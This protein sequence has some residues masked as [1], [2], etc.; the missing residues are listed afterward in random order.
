MGLK[1]ST[2]NTCVPVVWQQCDWHRSCCLLKIQNFSVQIFKCL[3]NLI[4]LGQLCGWPYLLL[5]C[6]ADIRP[7]WTLCC[8]HPGQ[9]PLPDPLQL[10]LCYLTLSHCVSFI[11]T[12][13]TGDLSLVFKSRG[14]IW[15]GSATHGSSPG[16]AMFNVRLT[17]G[18]LTF[19]VTLGRVEFQKTTWLLLT[20]KRTR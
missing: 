2:L 4:K 12:L 16:W 8:Q 19:L 3:V 5:V 15:W 13:E 18:N 20:L 6:W 7:W 14:W 17:L 1:R 11:Q 10:V 9:V